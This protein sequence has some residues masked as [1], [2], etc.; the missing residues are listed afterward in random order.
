M[1][2]HTCSYI[3]NTARFKVRSTIFQHN[4]GSVKIWKIFQE[5]ILENSFQRNFR[6]VA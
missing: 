6:T 3:Y 5:N 4:H 1:A 2:K